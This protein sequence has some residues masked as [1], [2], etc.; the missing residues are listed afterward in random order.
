MGRRELDPER[1][2]AIESAF[3]EWRRRWPQAYGNIVAVLESHYT[4]GKPCTLDK[5][6]EDTRKRDYTDARGLPFRGIDNTLEPAIRRAILADR[7]H[8]RGFLDGGRKSHLDVIGGAD[9]GAD[10]E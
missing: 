1:G 9:D 3:L 2:R 10:G 7:P 8:L 4:W 6:I 5:A